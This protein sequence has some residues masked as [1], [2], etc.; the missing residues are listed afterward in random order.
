MI[1]LIFL[2]HRLITIS[3][4]VFKKLIDT[5]YVLDS[6]RYINFGSPSLTDNIANQGLLQILS[7]EFMVQGGKFKHKLLK[8]RLDRRFAI[9]QFLFTKLN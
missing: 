9:K 4:K 6:D 3:Q 1:P 5:F 8:L 2:F 7:I